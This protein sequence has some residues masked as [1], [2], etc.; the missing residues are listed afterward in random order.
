MNK[1]GQKVKSQFDRNI[2]SFIEKDCDTIS[3]EDIYGIIHTIGVKEKQVYFARVLHHFLI[4]KLKEIEAEA[5]KCKESIRSSFQTYELIIVTLLRLICNKSCNKNYLLI[6]TKI[7]RHLGYLTYTDANRFKYK[8]Y[9]MNNQNN[10]S[11]KKLLKNVNYE[12]DMTASECVFISENNQ[13]TSV[14]DQSI[15]LDAS[16]KVNPKESVES[17]NDFRQVISEEVD[18]VYKSK[19]IPM[20]QQYLTHRDNV[21]QESELSEVLP[22]LKQDESDLFIPANI[23][24]QH[25]SNQTNRDLDGERVDDQQQLDFA[26][27]PLTLNNCVFSEDEDE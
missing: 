20:I 19:I 4:V 26:N 16:E 7:L 22:T 13:E 25:S 21:K 3:M 14:Q 15:C 18:F 23:L 24:L 10:V 27:L 11:L 12:Y 9:R 8:V 17:H 1:T 5:K 2:S 6:C